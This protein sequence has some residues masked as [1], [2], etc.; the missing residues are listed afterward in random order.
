MKFAIALVLIALI[1]TIT[2]SGCV[3]QPSGPPTGGLTQEQAE[4]KALQT[5][6]QEMN[7]LEEMTL[8]D[9]ENELLQQG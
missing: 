1:L 3:Q 8:E 7:A 5:L 6:D 9:L 4:Q 2:I